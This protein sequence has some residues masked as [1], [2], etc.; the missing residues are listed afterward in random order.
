MAVEP[1]TPA[2]PS[3][4]NF[5]NFTNFAIECLRDDRKLH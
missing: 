3:A 4:A 1:A 5:T 2:A